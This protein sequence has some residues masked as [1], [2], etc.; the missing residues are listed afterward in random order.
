MSRICL[1]W[2]SL[3]SCG[4]TCVQP[5]SPPH[6]P[7]K[8]SPISSIFRSL[9]IPI[10]FCS[11]ASGKRVTISPRMTPPTSL[12]PKPSMLRC[13]RATAPWPERAAGRASS[14]YEWIDSAANRRRNVFCGGSCKAFRRIRRGTACRACRSSSSG[15]F[16]ARRDHTSNRCPRRMAKEIK[17]EVCGRRPELSR[18]RQTPTDTP[19]AR[20]LT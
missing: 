10:S 16:P 19:A 1:T 2:K 20:L 8:L 15:T 7:P 14:C 6:A 3:R 17:P 12:L 5:A 13:S 9:A 11:R 18:T 4:A